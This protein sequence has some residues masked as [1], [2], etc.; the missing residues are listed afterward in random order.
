MASMASSLSMATI[1]PDA[2]LALRAAAFAHGLAQLSGSPG[3]EQFIVDTFAQTVRAEQASLATH[4]E[5]AERLDIK[6]T[7]GYPLALVQHLEIFAG[8][9]LMG[10]A[11]VS[12]EPRL[13]GDVASEVSGRRRLRYRTSSCI[14]VPLVAG[15]EVL[16]V[17]SLADRVDGVAFD[18][19][20]L[21]IARTLAAPATL[22]LLNERLLEQK[23]DL[24]QRA[25]TDLLTGLFNRS[26]FRTRLEEELGRAER[27]DL[28]LAL[29]IVD[30]DGF[31]SLND[32][33]GHIAGDA[34]LRG[35]AAVIR[36]SV[37]IFDV[38]AR[39]GGDEFVILLHA[40]EASA[41]QSAERLRQRIEAAAF[42][43]GSTLPA[44]AKVTVS[45]GL[46]G[47][48]KNCTALDLLASADRA[49]Y[50]AKAG[51]KNCVR[52]AR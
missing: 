26:Y 29:L 34:V 1:T 18:A 48:S 30:V 47:R 32:S 22:A 13:I 42:E 10:T 45:I 50:A 40:N 3:M 52:I 2:D 31:K 20:D 14:L 27:Y 19:T 11:L 16:A 51:G 46:A 25:A 33:A 38:C 24:E 5:E 43:P 17:I 6:A 28:D 35:V 36:R 4:D 49:L 41:L 37:R 39:Q 21:N 12:R 15:Q 23:R 44:G 8:N 9:S 7:H